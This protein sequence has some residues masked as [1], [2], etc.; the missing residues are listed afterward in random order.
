[1]SIN[2]QTSINRQGLPVYNY[3][4]Y[5][6][7][8]DTKIRQAGSV[9]IVDLSGRITMGITTTILSDTIRKLA[10]EGHRHILLNL[11]DVEYIDSSGLGDLVASLTVVAKQGGAL[12]L[13]NPTKRFRDL[14]QITHVAPLFQVFDDEAA[15]A[16]SFA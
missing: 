4:D 2:R 6:M 7:I 15:A 10:G 16:R 12:K 9:T 14:L 1:M 13:L 8:L 11:A 5:S 3:E